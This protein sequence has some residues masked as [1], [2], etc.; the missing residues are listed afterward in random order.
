[1]A[2]KRQ[3]LAL[4]GRLYHCELPEL[5]HLIKEQEL[6]SEADTAKMDWSV[7][8]ALVSKDE[9]KRTTVALW[10]RLVDS[11]SRKRMPAIQKQGIKSRNSTKLH[12]EFKVSGTVE[13]TGLSYQRLMRQVKAAL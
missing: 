13:K 4:M 1:M 9:E 2:D 6:A 8:M 10:I 5:K 3:K 11:G 7:A 12:T